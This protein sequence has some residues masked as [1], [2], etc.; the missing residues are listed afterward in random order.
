MDTMPRMISAV[1]PRISFVVI[2]F[3]LLS[4]ISL[5]QQALPGDS[6]QPAVAPKTEDNNPP[7]ESKR[8]LGIIPNYRTSPSLQNYEPLTI[9]EKF[10]IASQDAFDRGT[11]GL[12]LLFGG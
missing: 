8:L 11:V 7:V 12:A 4:S 2:V 10:K 3:A 6:T 1:S 9:G 5:C